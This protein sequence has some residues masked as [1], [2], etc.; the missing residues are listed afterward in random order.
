MDAKKGFWQIKLSES[1]SKLTTFWTPF[2]RYRWLRLPFGVSPAPDIFGQKSQEIVQG[3]IGVEKLA[4]DFVIFDRGKTMEAAIADHNINLENLL[5]RLNK[6]NCKLNKSKIKL[7]QTSV[8]FFGHTLTCNGLEPDPEK[9][10]AIINMKSSSDETAL[11]HF[12]GMLTYLSRY[13]PDL[14]TSTE[15]LR[16]LTR[17]KADWCWSKVEEDEFKKLK[18]L[19]ASIE[20]Q[21]YFDV[22]APVTLECDASSTGLGAALFQ[23]NRVVGYASRTLNRTERNY[24]QIEKEL[25]SIVFGCTRFDQFLAG[26][27]QIT[28]KTDHK[29]LLSIFKKPLIKAPKRLQLMLMALQRYKLKLEYVR[30]KDNVVADTLSRA[31]EELNINDNEIWKKYDVFELIEEIDVSQELMKMSLKKNLQITPERLKI[32]EQATNSD[33]TLQKVKLYI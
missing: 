25:L 1:S 31:P 26:N 3:L 15:N 30:G 7:C 6:F 17:D 8:K 12:L 23:K 4:D 18:N 20:T 14:S 13:L 32:I 24:A 10:S 22:N 29:P 21:K 19:V 28:V 27:S 11:L 33:I 9:T 16:K 2:G 5:I